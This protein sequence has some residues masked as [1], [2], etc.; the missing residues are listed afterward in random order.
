M[1][2]QTNNLLCE[3]IGLTGDKETKY[4]KEECKQSSLTS[5]V[6]FPSIPKLWKKE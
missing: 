1:L 2:A 6:P 3:L 5:K 4:F